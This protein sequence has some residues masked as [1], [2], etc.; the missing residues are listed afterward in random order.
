MS[1][2]EKARLLDAAAHSLCAAAAA[3]RVPFISDDPPAKLI[4]QA[5]DHGIELASFARE[6]C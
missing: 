1:N 6:M 2:E 3:L 5:I 4:T